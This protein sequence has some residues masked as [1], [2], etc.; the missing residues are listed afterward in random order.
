MQVGVKWRRGT[1][2]VG[3]WTSPRPRPLEQ[4]C[5]LDQK[6]RCRLNINLPHSIGQSNG[7]DQ[8]TG[9][10]P[11]RDGAAGA[12]QCVSDAA[13]F[14][15]RPL[16]RERGLQPGKICPTAQNPNLVIGYTKSRGSL[17]FD[18]A[19]FGCFSRTGV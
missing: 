9:K 10:P 12:F 8:R 3:P 17:S 4:V 14:L 7:P 5:R 15:Y 18:G 6:G 11:G 19:D 13:L 16:V 2:K 1:K